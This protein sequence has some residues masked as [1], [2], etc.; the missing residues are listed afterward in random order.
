LPLL[1]RAGKNFFIENARITQN[2]PGLF[3]LRKRGKAEQK[4]E[5]HGTCSC[6]LKPKDAR[7][8]PR[9]S[10][11]PVAGSGALPWPRRSGPKGAENACAEF[12]RV[13]RWAAFSHLG[14]L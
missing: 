13:A 3:F 4:T 2:R 10:T 8:R 11:A 1:R 9:A 12:V 14:A 6:S 5:R 7:I